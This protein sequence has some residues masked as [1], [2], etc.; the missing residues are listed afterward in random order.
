MPV[1][2]IPE[3]SLFL[4]NKM[5]EQMPSVNWELAFPK[6][7][8]ALARKGPPVDRGALEAHEQD[9]VRKRGG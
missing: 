6:K 3:E 2:H 4:A 8:G 7:F 9:K 1:S 5:K